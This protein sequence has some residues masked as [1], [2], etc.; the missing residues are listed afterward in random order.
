MFFYLLYN[1]LV[2]NFLCNFKVAC[3]LVF[4]NLR[5]ETKGSLSESSCELFAEVSSLQ[6]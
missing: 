5:S 3:S 4:N 2:Y 6:S 1:F